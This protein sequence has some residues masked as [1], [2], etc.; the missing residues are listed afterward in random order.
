MAEVTMFLTKTPVLL[1]GGRM[2][3]R[4][5]EAEAE[6]AVR[7]SPNRIGFDQAKFDAVRLRD[8]SERLRGAKDGSASSRTA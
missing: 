8:L 4:N 2:T 7:T 3:A 5:R 6:Q 1:R